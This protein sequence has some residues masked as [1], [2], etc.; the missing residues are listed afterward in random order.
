[1]TLAFSS[2]IAVPKYS[3]TELLAW[4]LTL[5]LLFYIFDCFLIV[6]Q[7]RMASSLH[8]AALHC[9][10]AFSPVKIF[11]GWTPRRGGSDNPSTASHRK[12]NL[13]RELRTKP[14]APLLTIKPGS[15]SL[16]SSNL[17]S[18]NLCCCCIGLHYVETFLCISQGTSD[19]INPSIASK[20]TIKFYQRLSHIVS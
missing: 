14:E 15:C 6:P 20:I 7:F 10:F 8:T 17:N 2:K 9:W 18:G 3:L 4:L 13:S 16:Q 19:A 1:M 11:T 12:Y 5:V